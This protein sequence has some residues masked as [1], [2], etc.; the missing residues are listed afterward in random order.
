MVDYV[1]NGL[2]KYLNRP[3]KPFQSVNRSR[4]STFKKGAEGGISRIFTKRGSI[5]S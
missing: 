1:C 4:R 5:E 2:P 3:L